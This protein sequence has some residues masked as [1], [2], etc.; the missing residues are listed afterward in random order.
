MQS[1]S[2]IGI[3]YD[4][5]W[6]SLWEQRFSDPLADAETFREKDGRLLEIGK[7]TQ[8]I[9]EIQGQYMGLIT[10]HTAGWKAI[11]QVCA[12][13]GEATAKTDMTALIQL[14]LEKGI[15]VA[16]VP[17]DG[18]WCEVDSQKDLALYER[19]LRNH[20]WSHDWQ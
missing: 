4:T 13:L 3:T 1:N 18:K 8:R 12:D 6:K 14:L 9:E 17:V 20:G 2:P 19:M 5:Q 15:L 11:E 16:A 10:L 7:K